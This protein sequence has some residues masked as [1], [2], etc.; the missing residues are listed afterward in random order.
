MKDAARTFLFDLLN[1]PS[2]SGFEADGQRVWA[3]YVRPAAD[4]VGADV[5]GS[6]WATRWGAAG[7]DSPSV[8]VEAHADEIGFMVNAVTDEGFLHVT[9]IGG[10]DRAT[11]RGKRVNVLGSK[12]P[13]PGVIGN[14]AV[15]LRDTKDEKVPELHQL[16]VDVGAS[17]REE[18]AGLGVRV[19]H[20]IVFAEAVG[21][22]LPGKLTG[23]AL[24]NRIGGFI[25]AEVL[26]RVAAGDRVPATLHAVNCVQEEVGGHGAKMMAYRLHPTVAVVLDV[27]HATD[28]PGIEKAKHGEVKLGAGPTVSHG[29]A[30][31]PRVVERLVEV[32]AA[33][34]I[35]V[36]HE[37]SSQYTGTDTDDIFNA[38]TGVPTALL[39]LPMRYMHST[40]ET[41]A[42]GDVE[43]CIDLL[44]AFVRSVREEDTFAVEL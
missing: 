16:Y 15:H 28:S 2:P 20:P 38:R 36:Q 34:E 35:P 4:F 27:T 5:Y 24:D 6:A 18:V 21:E 42:L 30:N 12:G 7:E 22:L 14:T 26:R 33:A 10:A 37:A 39:S 8:M 23:R 40:V 9:R 19:G 13:V 17:N 11:A 32:A 1:T 41:V 44:E 31:H 25:I 3:G 43:R 29:R